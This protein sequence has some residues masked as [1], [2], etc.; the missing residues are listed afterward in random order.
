MV[1]VN[2]QFVAF[3]QSTLFALQQRREALTEA[4]RRTQEAAEAE[5]ALQQQALAT[6][7]QLQSVVREYSTFL[8]RITQ[9]DYRASL[10][11]ESLAGQQNLPPELLSLGRYLNTTVTS[12]VA[13]LDDAR[14]AQQRYLRQAWTGIVE[15]GAVPAG[16]R[17]RD[18][19]GADATAQVEIAEDAWLDPMTEAVQT[20][21]L[22]LGEKALAVPLAAGGRAQLIGAI[23]IRRE[24]GTAWSEHELNIVAAVADQLAQTIENLRLLDETRRRA[25]REQTASVIAGHIREAVE[26]EVVLERALAELGQALNAE[27]GAVYLALDAQQEEGV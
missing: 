14:L 21:A 3:M 24:D 26:I 23:G 8:E 11:L 10:D 5:R 22:A 16:Y 1:A 7:Q 6:A 18:A 20:K 17:Y 9:G 19:D 27:R 15:T 4:N 13:A 25:A 12:L 2:Q